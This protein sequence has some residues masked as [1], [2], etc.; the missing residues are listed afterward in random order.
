MDTAAVE[1]VA[2]IVATG[3]ISGL[4]EQAALGVVARLRDRVKAAFGSDRRSA[5]DLELA[6][7]EPSDDRI[8]ALVSALVW[9]ARENRDFARELAGWAAEYR[10]PQAPLTQHIHAARDAYTSGRD[11][12]VHQ[13]PEE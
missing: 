1:A 2:T 12:T 5:Q 6:I 3:A 4:G 13:R 8:R 10:P 9:H 7:A 11:M